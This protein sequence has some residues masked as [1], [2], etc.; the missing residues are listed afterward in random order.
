MNSRLGPRV[1]RAER[2]R[3]VPIARSLWPEMSGATSGSSARR[4]VERSTSM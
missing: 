1:T 4:S 2:A 3:R